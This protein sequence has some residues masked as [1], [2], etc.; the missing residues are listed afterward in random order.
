MSKLRKFIESAKQH[1]GYWVEK[2]KNDF[3]V[4]IDRAIARSGINQKMLAAH[5]GTSPAYVNKVLRGDANLT[6]E[7]MVKLSRAAHCQLHICVAPESNAV[8]WFEIIEGSKAAE[9]YSTA[10]LWRDHVVEKK[11]EQPI[12]IAA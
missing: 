9:S 8:R 2:A 4:A 12:P 6:I 1:D 5:L 3:A 7:S 11:N 10:P